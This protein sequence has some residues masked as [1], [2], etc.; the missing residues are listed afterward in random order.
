MKEGKR[1]LPFFSGILISTQHVCSEIRRSIKHTIIQ[2]GEGATGFNK[3]RWVRQ[4][5]RTANN[6]GYSGGTICEIQK[7]GCETL[8]AKDWACIV[9]AWVKV[10]TWE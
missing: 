5:S 10:W 2:R 3:S 4:L 1:Y 9:T 6:I 8:A 7:G